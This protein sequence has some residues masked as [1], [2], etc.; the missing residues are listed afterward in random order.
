MSLISPVDLEH[1]LE[2]TAG[3]WPALAGQRLFITGGTGFF[4]CWL[5]ETLLAANRKLDLGLEATVLSRDPDAFAQR[6]PHLAATS[7]L[8]WVRGSAVDF[9]PERVAREL[10]LAPGRLAFDAVIHLAT[11]AD[12]ARTLA[13][14]AAAVEVIAGST[15]RALEFAGA[16]GARRFLFTSS[17]SVYGRQPAELEKM[18]EDFPGSSDPAHLSA[19][20]AISGQAKRAAEELCA[21][22]WKQRGVETIVARC[23]AFAGPHLPL[24]GKFAFGNFL[25][26][27]LAGRDIVIT[28]DGTPVRSYLYAADLAIWL[29]TLLARGAPGRVYNVGSEHA[30]SIREL[31]ETVARL[32]APGRRV[33]ILQAPASSAPIERYVP[34]TRRAREEL[35]LREFVG[36]EE[37]ILRTAAWARRR[38]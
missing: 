18:S 19:A 34:S 24:D 9:T 13:E 10:G 8:R 3:V 4:G 29:W 1:V 2:H 14:P 38:G 26:D 12:N 28:G 22:F 27:A 23:F 25:A 16:V 6:M 35:G 31:A 7:G 17:G 30:V 5:L 15:R 20:Y 36:L 33:K 32:V 21:T 37:A 11:E